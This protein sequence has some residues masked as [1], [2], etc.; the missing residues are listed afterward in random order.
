MTPGKGKQLRGVDII[1]Y[2][3]TYRSKATTQKQFR[4][5]STLTFVFVF[6]RFTFTDEDGYNLGVLLFPEKTASNY[7]YSIS[8]SYLHIHKKIFAD[9][10]ATSSWYLQFTIPRC[11][12]CMCVVN[13]VL[14][15]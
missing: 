15:L 10:A 4:S 5:E 12:L 11:V 9:T 2:Y 1:N 8:F 13:F 3:S 6:Y 14:Y 7:A